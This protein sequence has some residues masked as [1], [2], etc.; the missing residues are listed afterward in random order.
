[1]DQVQPNEVET[2][3]DS[4]SPKHFRASHFEKSG[5]FESLDTFSELE[6]RY[7][8]LSPK[9]KGHAFE[10]FAEAYLATQKQ[11]Q[12]TEVWP[13]NSIPRDL[14]QRLHLP[15][16]EI[17]VDGV[18][19]DRIGDYSAYQVKFRTGRPSLRWEE[20]SSFF[21]MSD[22]A[23]TR[24]LVTN[25]NDLA[26]V[27]D[28]R[29]RFYC[30]RGNDLDRLERRD[31]ELI[32]DWL[33]GVAVTRN[34][35]SPREDQVQAIQEIAHG[36]ES[37]DRVTAVM[38]CGTGKTLVALWLAERLECRQILV[39][40]PSLALMRQ[41]LHVWLQETSWDRMS[42]RCVCSDPTVRKGMDELI[43]HKS[44][45][46]FPVNTNS[47]EVADYLDQPFDGVRVV[48]STYQSAHVVAE[49]LKGHSLF[50]LGVFDEAHKTVGRQGKS[51]SFAIEDKNLPIKK[52][53]FL[54]A[55]PRHYNVSKRDKQGD[56]KLVYSMDVPESYGPL[57][58][59]LSFVEAES[60]GII[61][62]Y[63]VIISH[64]TTEMVADALRQRGE[65]IVEGDAIKTRQVANQIALEQAVRKH[66]LKRIITFHS[67]V[68]PAKSFVA[69]GGEGVGAQ[70][71]GFST[72]HVNGKIPT[73][74]REDIL[75]DFSRADCGLVSNA[76][77]LTEG[78]DLPAV[79]MV[80]FMAPKKSKVDI[81]QATGRAMRKDP[82]NPQKETGYVLLPL[83]VESSADES[84]E[85]ALKRTDYEEVWNVLEA[86]QEHDEVLAEIIQQMQ[87]DKGRTGGFD[88]SRFREKIE[89]LGPSM[90]LDQLRTGIAIR[91]IERLGS[92][93]DL[94]YGELQR[95]RK[96][97]TH[98]NV[99]KNWEENQQL[100]NWVE[101]QR[102]LYKKGKLSD[103][104]VERLK[105]I[106]FVWD[107]DEVAWEE[108]FAALKKYKDKYD[109]CNVPAKWEKNPKLGAWVSIQ[110]RSYKKKE[111]LSP[112]QIERLE[113]IDFVWD[114]LEAKWEEMFAELKKYKDKQGHCD[115]SAKDPG[116]K[117]LASWANTQRRKYKKKKKGL[118]PEQ[119]ERLVEIGFVWDLLEA[120]W[121][122]MFVALE[123]FEE[124]HGHCN[125]TRKLSDDSKLHSWV[126]KQRTDYKKGE[127][128]PERITRLVKIGF[129][130]DML[131]AE[132]KEMFAALEKFEE[133]HGHCNVTARYSANL[134]LGRWVANLR[135]RMKRGKLSEK[136]I[137][138]LKAIGFAFTRR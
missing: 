137:S 36:L 73:A 40:V 122:K 100:A 66:G 52:R 58:H 97:N 128:S 30:V 94:R 85:D 104:R 21:G 91:C 136:R 78:V 103:E 62:G 63:K 121:E 7:A 117:K 72:Y 75:G 89:V 34:L 87:V 46:D 99:P 109:D 83:F 124:E 54:T 50:D 111:R 45:L 80:A 92:T 113:E 105:A 48:F 16:P 55:T 77:C 108:M 114:I 70:L 127:L 28:E 39:L 29:V 116:D 88:E 44:D 1:M 47:D 123:K 35:K 69:S 53:V 57:V 6:S 71:P 12:A 41:T 25:C 49:A 18:F 79:D 37:H 23:D 129:V 106:D 27:V 107:P 43:I 84:L 132:W 9:D 125:V 110:R 118:S 81:V 26:T 134:K 95:F 14:R 130:W 11:F 101:H 86:M 38:A 17:G 76:R 64:V 74:K 13:A 20:L 61:C 56:A 65:V 5:L 32:S 82:G 3:T 138:R 19:Q 42:Y 93:W 67:T 68:P 102:I 60:L 51:F 90:T 119:I 4:V 120:E 22:R 126:S 131:E 135:S 59:S 115:V 98:C 133:E 24:V 15:S 96:D 112:E 31:F 10:V 2:L 33:K 8:E